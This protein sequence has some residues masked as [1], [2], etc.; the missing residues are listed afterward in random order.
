MTGQ[1]LGHYRLDAPLGAGGMGTVYR[2]YDT[3]LE[4]IVAIKLLTAGSTDSGSVL[5]EARLASALN[6]P[7]I[8]AV[9]EVAEAGD[10]AFIVME[11][12]DGQPL[13]GLIPP[14]GLPHDD[15]VRYGTQVADAIA[16]AHERGVVHCDLK[17]QNIIITDDGRAK[18]LD[19]GIAHRL[20]AAAID[21]TTNAS[22]TTLTPAIAGTLPYMAPEV[23]RGGASRM[24][25]A[26]SGRSVCCC[27]RWPAAVGRSPS[28][29]GTP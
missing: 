17:P 3:R 20:Q 29:R 14:R 28:S 7:H 23:L 25:G 19:F 8:C 24:D 1:V 21:A 26:T 6:H 18:V 5:R 15:L 11:F 9:Y 22:V 13:S 12:V 16:H 2:A 27:T 4:R 10:L